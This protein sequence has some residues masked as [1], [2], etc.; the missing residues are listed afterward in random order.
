M[1]N[2]AKRV[3][4]KNAAGRGRKAKEGKGA[5]MKGSAIAEGTG[6]STSMSQGVRM[7]AEGGSASKPVKSGTKAI[8]LGLLNP[9]NT[10]AF[11]GRGVLWELRRLDEE[12]ARVE[13]SMRELAGISLA[14]PDRTASL[15]LLK[16]KSG[17]RMLRWRFN[18]VANS[19]VTDA[20]ARE[21]FEGYPEPK[22]SWYIQALE[23]GIGFTNRHRLL[24]KARR[25]LQTQLP[26]A[27]VYA[28]EPVRGFLPSELQKRY[29][30]FSA[31]AA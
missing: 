29:E 14:I 21:V 26:T 16:F 5:G 9:D 28:R 13:S 4:P 11:K 27:H 18:G 2:E 15:M 12:L 22:R 3:A 20:V 6:T 30:A 23:R 25:G 31:A 24:M 8:V 10:N 7:F 1:R 19:Y 17:R